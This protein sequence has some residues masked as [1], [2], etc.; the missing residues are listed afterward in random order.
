MKTYRTAKII[1][2]TLAGCLISCLSF[3]QNSH[4]GEPEMNQTLFGNFDQSKDVFTVTARGLGGANVM[5][6]PM[7]LSGWAKGDVSFYNG[8]VYRNADLE[9]DLV[10]NELHFKDGD[11]ALSFT[12]A[13]K[14]FTITDTSGGTSRIAL[15]NSE[16]PAY[17]MRKSA[18]YLVFANGPRV[19]FISYISKHVS[20]L[21]QYNAGS[22]QQYKITEDWYLY[23]VQTDELH[24]INATL[25]SVQKQLHNM[26][27][28]LD[29]LLTG[30]TT[31]Q[32]TEAQVA[33]IVNRINSE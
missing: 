20:E 29:Y 8:K 11:K 21:Y 13:V 18:F 30:I 2:F 26:A 12:E 14:A 7:L 28:N 22:K 17:G 32:V 15:F 27:P 5:G 1:M 23:D 10:R 19:H 16:Y 6:S 33:S 3:S 31:K 4:L 9:F 25:K 24:P